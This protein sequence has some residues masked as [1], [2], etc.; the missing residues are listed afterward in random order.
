ME[1][2]FLFFIN[3]RLNAKQIEF[4]PMNR[5]REDWE[6]VLARLEFEPARYLYDVVRYYNFYF[7]EKFSLLVDQSTIVYSNNRPVGIWPLMIA[8]ENDRT[9]I[10]MKSFG[11][12]V[13]PPQIVADYPIRASKRLQHKLL[14]LLDSYCNRNSF[15]QL[16]LS[17]VSL[18]K[19]ELVNGIRKQSTR[20]K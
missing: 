3:E 9:P 8:K 6:S 20:L 18:V 1:N 13:M 17:D 16:V 15:D 19:L 12:G 11:S 7:A 10:T 5:K 2:E 4:R 14:E